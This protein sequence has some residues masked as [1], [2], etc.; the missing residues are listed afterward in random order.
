MKFKRTKNAYKANSSLNSLM[1]KQ[2]V[3]SAVGNAIKKPQTTKIINS[4]DLLMLSLSKFYSV[5]SNITRILSIIE[6]SLASSTAQSSTTSRISL[7]LID[8][9]V[10]NYSKK[11]N[12]V[13]T[14]EKS[15]NVIHFNVYLSYRSQ[16]KAYSK[17]LFDP[18][19]RRDRITF[20][21]DVDKSVETTIGQ[22][23]M[24]RWILQNDILDYIIQHIDEIETDMIQTQKTNMNKKQNDENIKVKVLQTDNGVVVQKRKK[25]NQLSKCM[26]KN[27]N[28]FSGQRVVKFD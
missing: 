23:N 9:F 11:Y 12:T 22:L 3:N 27:M 4:K 1:E 15:N 18:F 21:Y 6:P 16:L 17:Q 24:F 8:W 26:V 10:T 14:K 19:R 20:F 5:K 13:I 7:R 2:T 28:L 25:R